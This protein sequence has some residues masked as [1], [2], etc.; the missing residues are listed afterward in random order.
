MKKC[1]NI[2]IIVF[3]FSLFSQLGLI[4]Q[5]QAIS[6][7]FAQTS[8]EKS[9]STLPVSAT[10]PDTQQPAT[11]I[12]ISP[13][14]GELVSTNKPQFVWQASSD[15][16]AI[17]HYQ[18]FVDDRLLVDNIMETG[19]FNLYNLTYNNELERFYLDSKFN[20][21]QGIHSWK[22]TAV[23]TA[24]L[25]T[26]SAIWS[27]TVDSIPP[28]FTLTQIG[29]KE[30]SISTQNLSTISEEPLE[31]LINEPLLK[32]AGEAMSEVQ[33]TAII[34]EQDNHLNKTNINSQGQWEHPLPILPRDTVIT[35]N[36]VIVD[37]ARH[38]SVLENVKIIIPSETPV[39]KEVVYDLA[40]WITPTPFWK[41][42]NQTWFKQV[43]QASGPWIVVLI[44]S[45]PVL[46]ATILLMNKLD[47]IISFKNLIK[48]WQALGA[49]PHENRE[50]W[51]FDSQL[52]FNSI[53]LAGIPFARIFAISEPKHPG[54]PPFYQT[55]LTDHRG[56]YLPLNLPINKYR[57]SIQHLDYRYPT[58]IDR[59][60]QTGVVDF[61]QAQEME[62]NIDHTSLSLQIPADS[63]R[64]QSLTS[65]NNLLSR[66]K[67]R[68]WSWATQL[69][70]WLARI[71]K[72]NSLLVLANILL[73]IAASIY[74]TTIVNLIALTIYL[75]FGLYYLFKKKLFANIS[76]VVIDK[77]GN[78]VQHAIVRLISLDDAGHIF[79]DVTD[80]SGRFN[81]YFKQGQ[82]EIRVNK[83]G[84]KQI[85]ETD[86]D[87]QVEV[88]A[89]WAKKRL[90][91]MMIK[92]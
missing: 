18:L 30:V 48:I 28:H 51:A 64:P 62:T 29:D 91:V 24:G 26:V 77:N 90:M 85:T 21:D 31:I 84:L 46:L 36:F 17:S 9:F 45:W 75:I 52:T 72:F 56:L 83:Y 86:R 4:F 58:L 41:I 1:F 16:V 88:K 14:N 50:G 35:L 69:Q 67:Y 63:D 43:L 13:E 79:A 3:F 60:E 53:R 6:T 68:G 70:V 19:V 74:W 59:P 87:K 40:R 76:G 11:P 34:P 42:I 81:F 7:V 66:F 57:L 73:A 82:F 47:W 32:G 55:V 22:I 39:P 38:V 61:Y 25:K 78:F 80:N 44:A 71:I 5:K 65:S 2:I 89:W 27:F 23:D 20:L 37:L 33:L 8:K 54:F 15:N 49:I 92:S 10:I 12:L